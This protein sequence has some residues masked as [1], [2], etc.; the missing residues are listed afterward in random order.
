MLVNFRLQFEDYSIECS[1]EE[2][3]YYEDLVAWWDSMRVDARSECFNRYDGQRGMTLNF[4]GGK[5]NWLN[6]Y[7]KLYDNELKLKQ[8]KDNA[9]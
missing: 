9:E 2:K 8:E 6:S 7:K 1:E 4:R 5:D 3:K